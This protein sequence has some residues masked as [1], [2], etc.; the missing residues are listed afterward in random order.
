VSDNGVIVED[1]GSSNGTKVGEVRL[2][3]NTPVAARPGD[4]VRFGTWKLVLHAGASGAVSAAEQTIM[5][6]AEDKTVVLSSGASVADTATPGQPAGDQA[7]AIALLNK[8][9]GI[10]DD[11]RIPEGMISL[12]RKSGNAVV[13]PDPYLSGRHAEIFAEPSGVYLVDIGSTNGTLVNGQKLEHHDRQ[14][15]LDGDE[16]QLG[17]TKYRFVTLAESQTGDASQNSAEESADHVASLDETEEDP[18]E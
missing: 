2:Q 4:T 1:L 16:V 12:G 6:P 7:P 13:L 10:C 3:P 9:E 5:A 18:S 14:L 11:I 8:L 15:L 17:Q